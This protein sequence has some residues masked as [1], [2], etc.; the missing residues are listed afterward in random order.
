[1]K[2]SQLLFVS[3]TVLVVTG[4]ASRA[5]SVAPASVS[6]VEYS[7]MSCEETTEALS[8]ARESENALARKQ[9]NAATAD[10][11]SVFLVLLPLGSVFGGDVS[12]ELAQA[13]GEVGALERAVEMNCQAEQRAMSND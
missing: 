12:G 10:A 2:I 6:A 3:L 4:C 9:N 7:N 13:K 5:S 11:A 8:S 1:M